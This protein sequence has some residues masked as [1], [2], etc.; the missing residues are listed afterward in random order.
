[1]FYDVARQS[2]HHVPHEKISFTMAAFTMIPTPQRHGDTKSAPSKVS[3]VHRRRA[4]WPRFP[5]AHSLFKLMM[6]KSGF[7][8]SS[9][10]ED[11]YL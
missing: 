9:F 1:M 2:S 10:W 6:P 5:K 3:K 4:R 11:T 8:F 7:E